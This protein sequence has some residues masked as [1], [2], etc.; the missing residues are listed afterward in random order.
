MTPRVGVQALALHATAADAAKLTLVTGLSRFPVFRG[1]LDEVGGTIHLS[2][3]L[4]LDEDKCMLV[5]VADLMTSAP[6]VPHSLPADA[7]QVR[8][9]K[10]RT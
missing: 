9:R 6:L 8:L 3:V 5:Q 2:G 10:P 1:T 7:L 4:G